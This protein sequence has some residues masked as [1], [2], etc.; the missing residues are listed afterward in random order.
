MGLGVEGFRVQ[1]FRVWG[2]EPE[3]SINPHLEGPVYNRHILWDP[4]EN[5][6]FLEEY[7]SY[8]YVAAKN[9]WRP[10]FGLPEVF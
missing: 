8:T 7:D 6:P 2:L 5:L 9:K 10:L 4:H 3:D 1:D